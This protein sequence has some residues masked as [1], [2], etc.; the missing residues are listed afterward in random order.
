MLI[1][2]EHFNKQY[3]FIKNNS[4]ILRKSYYFF[5]LVLDYLE[6]HFK[7]KNHIKKILFY[8]HKVKNESFLFS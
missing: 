8:L 4:Y 1:K 7:I 6:F 3:N 2:I 5:I